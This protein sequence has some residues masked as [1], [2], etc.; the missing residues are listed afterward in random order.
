MPA[1]IDIHPH[2]ISPDLKRYPRAPLGGK[3][4]DWSATRPVSLEQLIVAMDATGI[5][6]AA[7]VQ[8]STCYG[9][10]NSY[11][12]DAV[13]AYPK[14]FTGVF[15]ADV[16]APDATIKMRHWMERGLTGMR[17]FTFGSTMSEQ[18]S[19]L[20]DP[21]SYPAWTYAA[22]HGLSICMQ[23]SASGIPQLIKMIERFPNVKIL[24]DHMARPTL[25][26]GP[27]YAAA[28]SLFGLARYPSVY[29]KLTK[30]NFEQAMT[31]SATPETFFPKLVSEF[32]AERL[33]WGSNYP[34]SEGTLP[35]ILKLAQET[36]AVLP[37]KDQDWIFAKTA[38]VIYPALKD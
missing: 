10:D 7:I 35:D 37:Q 38:Q 25:D 8:A 23:M 3:Q 24:L 11:V 6:K 32:G 27:P 31:G 4:S 26:D 22:D 13:A 5:Q 33:A 19:W 14:R 17:L 1:V 34:S 20:D 2:I 15:S 21:K 30:R 9:H 12:A 29:L 18:A 36:L 16:L 28:A